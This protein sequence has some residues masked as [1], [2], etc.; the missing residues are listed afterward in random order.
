MHPDYR[1]ASCDDV[2]R[3][4]DECIALRAEVERLRAFVNDVTVLQHHACVTGDC[5]HN[6]VKD[7]AEAMT[8]EM[9]NVGQAAEDVL[10]GGAP[11]AGAGNA[12]GK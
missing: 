2:A 10:A 12:G 11:M 9:R 1:S 5:P 8:E 4:V 7:C 3:R 6:H